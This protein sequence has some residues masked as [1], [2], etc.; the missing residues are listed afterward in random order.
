MEVYT[1]LWELL[2]IGQR[3]RRTRITFGNGVLRYYH[4]GEVAK[5]C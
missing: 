5:L 2:S 1:E 3:R 4:P